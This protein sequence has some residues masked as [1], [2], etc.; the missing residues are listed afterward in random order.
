MNIAGWIGWRPVN[1]LSPPLQPKGNAVM[2]PNPKAG[3]DG[4]AT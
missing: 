2:I 1:G 3:E 4:E